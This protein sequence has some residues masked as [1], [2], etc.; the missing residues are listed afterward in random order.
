MDAEAA[1]SAH[2]D[3]VE[4]YNV[5][6]FV[7]LLDGEMREAV[8]R[9]EAR[10]SWRPLPGGAAYRVTS[11]RFDLRRQGKEVFYLAVG[12]HGRLVFVPPLPGAPVRGGIVAIG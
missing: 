6:G 8:P 7:V 1:A 12:G 5:P 4:F 10:F 3:Q 11:H 2:V 9:Q